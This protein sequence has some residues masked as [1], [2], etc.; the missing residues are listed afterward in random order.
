[1]SALLDAPLRSLRLHTRRTLRAT[2]LSP[3]VFLY[4]TLASCSSSSGTEQ[5]TSDGQSLA[6]LG[7]ADAHLLCPAGQVCVTDQVT[8][9]RSCQPYSDDLGYSSV[10]RHEPVQP[11][12]HEVVQQQLYRLNRAVSDYASGAADDASVASAYLRAANELFIQPVVSQQ[13]VALEEE[14]LFFE[15]APY[16]SSSEQAA[17]G[18]D[19]K[20][21]SMADMYAVAMQKDAFIRDVLGPIQNGDASILSECQNQLVHHEWRDPASGLGA[22]VQE[23]RANADGELNRCASAMIE[24]LDALLGYL[25]AKGE[26]LSDHQELAQLEIGPLREL[27][28]YAQMM[29][30]N[31]RRTRPS[32]IPGAPG[33]A[34]RGANEAKLANLPAVVEQYVHAVVQPIVRERLAFPL[35]FAPVTVDF[36]EETRD[37]VI[38]PE[39]ASSASETRALGYWAQVATHPDGFA[40]LVQDPEEVRTLGGASVPVDY[41]DLEHFR[42][43]ALRALDEA[44]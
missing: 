25:H 17:D 4:G 40:H 16:A 12:L 42:R 36:G 37:W 3:L 22:G 35:L 8:A 10:V 5:T 29:H 31:T 2:Y 9:E 19:A 18:L 24:S 6:D 13:L 38:R 30:D 7:C 32:P 14:Q 39:G 26:A 33:S 1:M 41:R 28:A 20:I 23:W 11:Q 44:S 27:R 15:R 34:A 21:A 43:I